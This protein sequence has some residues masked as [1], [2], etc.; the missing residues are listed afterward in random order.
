MNE[1]TLLQK[2]TEASGVSGFEGEIKKILE[3]ELKELGELTHDRMGSLICKKQGTGHSKVMLAAHMD[4]IGF[5]VTLITDKGFIKFQPIGGWW[6]QVLLAQRVIIKTAKGEVPGVIGSKPPHIL[7]VEDKKKMIEK[8]EMFI[9][10]GVANKDEAI[11]DLGIRPGDPI[12]PICP[13]TVMGNSKFILAKALD[14]R[15]GCAVL[16]E[17]FKT[18]QAGNHPNIVYGVGTVQE[19]VGL[20]GAVTSVSCVNPDIAIVI[21]TS[22]AG[23]VPGVK[24]EEAQGKLGDGPAI[25]LYDASMLPNIK[26]RDLAIKVAEE[27]NIPYQFEF[28]SGGGTDA[29][30]IHIHGC[31]VPT[32]AIGIPVRYIHSHAGIMHFDDYKNSIRLIKGLLKRLDDEMIKQIKSF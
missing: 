3:D 14:D 13:F 10:V 16:V 9:D 7:S 2:L 19:E 30:R 22:I 20:R 18:L 27:E 8:K 29:G 15:A 5:L 25:V 4:E 17:V 31:G 32:I 21:D 1:L 23:D 6:D 26:L 12:V 28:M 11:K 24:E